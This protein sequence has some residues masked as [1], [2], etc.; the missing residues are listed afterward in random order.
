[1]TAATA[2]ETVGRVPS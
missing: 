1:M 2:A